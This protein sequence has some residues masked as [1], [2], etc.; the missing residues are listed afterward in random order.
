MISWLLVIVVAY[1]FFALSAFGDKV[2][3]AGPPNPKSYTFYVGL[4]GILAVLAIPFVGLAVP[5]SSLF[6]WIAL[7]AIVFALGIYFGFSAVENFEVSK[8]AVTIGA[9][10]PIFIFFISWIFFGY[11]GLGFLSFLAFALLFLGSVIISF[12]KK[13]E[14]DRR[15][16][17]FTLFASLLYSFDYVLSKLIYTDISFAHGF[18]WRCIFIF[19]AVLFMLLWKSNRKEIFKKQGSK[20]SREKLKKIFLATQACG[21]AAS[22]LQSFAISLAPIAFLPIANSMRGLQYV[23][24]FVITVFISYF[25]PRILKEKISGRIVLR[26]TF[27][28]ILILAGLALLVF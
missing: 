24:L 17:K 6:F 10:Q 19:I 28:M 16:F 15:Y 13:I 22:I 27:S 23:F 5:S 20:A 26:K 1:F 7:D 11:Q 21:G 4:L 12:D 25:F 14:L 18:I 8:V 9:T 3:L 2:I